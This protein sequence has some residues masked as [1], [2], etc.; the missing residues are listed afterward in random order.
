MRKTVAPILL[1]GLFFVLTAPSTAAIPGVGYQPLSHTTIYRADP[2][3]QVLH[4]TGAA[5]PDPWGVACGSDLAC[6]RAWNFFPNSIPA[7]R[8]AYCA[9]Y[10][11]C[12]A[13]IRGGWAG[14]LSSENAKRLPEAM[15]YWFVHNPSRLHSPGASGGYDGVPTGTEITDALAFGEA[16]AIFKEYCLATGECDPNPRPSEPCLLPKVCGDP[17][18][19]CP[20][21]PVCPPKTCI[22]ARVKSTA[23]SCESWTL[24]GWRKARC[25]EA[26]AWAKTL[27]VCP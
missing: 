12:L 14:G 13:V 26:C 1:L 23:C 27:A 21:P 5:E 18:P 25:R 15:Q 16:L 4:A 10:G 2:G 17:C 7:A 3:G 8:D 6:L 22:P 24:V 20:P 19:F 11:V 9:H